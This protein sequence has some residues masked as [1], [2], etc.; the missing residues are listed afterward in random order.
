[1]SARRYC[2]CGR[3]IIIRKGL[4]RSRY[5]L[6]KDG[7]H[8][9]CQ[10]CYTAER[11]RVRAVTAKIYVIERLPGETSAEFEKRRVATVSVKPFSE[12]TI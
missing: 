8:V 11:D 3:R 5:A 6:P 2:D 10:R 1:M 7:D 12:G 9:L 4:G